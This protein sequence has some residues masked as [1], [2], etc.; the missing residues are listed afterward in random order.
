MNQV[1]ELHDSSIVA[2]SWADGVAI[3]MLCPVFVHRSE[4]RP[5]VQPGTV[6][7]RTA[8]FTITNAT[9]SAK[10]RLPA[11]VRAASLRIG[12]ID[13]LDVLP[14]EG[15]YADDIKLALD[16]SETEHLIVTGDQLLVNLTGEPS[17]L[18]NFPAA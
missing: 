5:G 12:T 6:C 11:A 18:E 4:G 9:V 10:G 16:L 2:V 15:M 1:I 3:V 17:H 13:Y 7:Q 14:E 8:M